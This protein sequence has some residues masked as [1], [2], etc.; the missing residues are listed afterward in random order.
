MAETGRK[1]ERREERKEGQKKK[2]NKGRRFEVFIAIKMPIKVTHHLQVHTASQPGTPASI[3]KKESRKSKK[4]RPNG[5]R[6]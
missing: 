4:G 2:R 5:I 3:K 1:I 6:R